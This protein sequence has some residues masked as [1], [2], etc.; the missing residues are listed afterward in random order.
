MSEGLR[1]PASRF[2]YT[3]ARYCSQV[4]S[5]PWGMCRLA[6]GLGSGLSSIVF[7]VAISK[8]TTK[9]FVGRFALFVVAF[10][11]DRFVYM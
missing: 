5:Y 11:V 6:G 7:V 4:R 1:A 9:K 2:C 10:V 8:K 3:N